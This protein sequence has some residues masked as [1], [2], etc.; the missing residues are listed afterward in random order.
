MGEF[1]FLMLMIRAPTLRG[2]QTTIAI[3][4][5][6][7]LSGV[8]NRAGIVKVLQMHCDGEASRRRKR[9]EGSKCSRLIGSW[10]VWCS[11]KAGRP[12]VGPG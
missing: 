12:T 8:A 10:G 7:L 1:A 9:A 5:E 4:D 3:K 2:V 6:V 11:A